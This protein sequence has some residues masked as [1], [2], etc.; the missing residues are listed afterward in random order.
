V[1]AGFLGAAIASACATAPLHPT[2]A[3]ARRVPIEN[4]V[5]FVER[6]GH[7]I[8][9]DIYQ[10]DQ[11]GR[12]PAVIVLHG[13]GGIH[14][15]AGHTV[16]RYAQ[17]LAE[18]GMVA[19]VVHYFDATGDFSAND[20]VETTNYFHWVR[21]LRDIVTRIRNRPDVRANSIGMLGHSLG[22]WLAVGAAAMDNRINRIVLFGA[23]LEPFLAD[24]IK[25]MPPT[26]MFHGDRDDVVP[27][28]D[29]D[30]L[31]AFMRQRRYPLEYHVVPGEGHVFGDSAAS[32]ALTHAARFLAPGR[33]RAVAR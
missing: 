6:D 5:I 27:L 16:S 17:A 30:S 26:L 33:R 24:S 11:G 14:L 19:F 12:H 9:V 28:A 22:A 8:E 2:A 25:R 23:G 3:A 32:E 20:S 1:L 29:A 7:R 31:A 10:P 4:N 18:Q 13:S 21:E 15:L